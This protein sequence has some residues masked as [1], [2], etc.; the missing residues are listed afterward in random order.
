[1]QR[2]SALRAAD[3]PA[4]AHRRLA[5]RRDRRKPAIQHQQREEHPVP[6]GA[7][8]ARRP[9]RVARR[10]MI[11]DDELLLYYYRD[12]LDAAERARI[13]TA[14]SEQPELA[15]RLQGSG[16]AP[17]R[18]RGDARSSRAR[19]SRSSAG[20][21]RWSARHA[22]MHKSDARVP[23][24]GRRWDFRWM[25]AA[26]AV[27]VVALIWSSGITTQSPPDDGRE[28]ARATRRPAR[29]MPPPMSAD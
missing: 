2:L 23:R 22:R 13:G 4:Q 8:A 18:G 21:S 10:I 26:A 16:G 29:A 15:R 9:A 20:K 6:R 24:A 7:Q 28:S 25:A 17:R 5:S 11:T 19:S 12:G 3:L 14:L 27:A 1:M